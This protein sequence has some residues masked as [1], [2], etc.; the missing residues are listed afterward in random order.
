MSLTPD[1]KPELKTQGINYW[2]SPFR[3][4]VGLDREFGGGGGE[5]AGPAQSRM[6]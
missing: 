5:K 3:A 2:W 6:L 4:R 1:C